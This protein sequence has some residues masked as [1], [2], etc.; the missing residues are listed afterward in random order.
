[1]FSK[2]SVAKFYKVFLAR[3]GLWENVQAAIFF[4]TLKIQIKL[5]S[6][7]HKLLK[8]NKDNQWKWSDQTV[9]NS[10][11]GLACAPRENPKT[12]R[13]RKSPEEGGHWQ[14]VETISRSSLRRHVYN[15]WNE[16]IFYKVSLSFTGDFSIRARKA[17]FGSFVRRLSAT[18]LSVCTWSAIIG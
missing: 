2:L 15:W 5:E 9:P 13:D 14:A 18:G 6:R 12:L 3:K 4:S 7:D 16:A 1:M 17:A 11:A 10:I 8:T